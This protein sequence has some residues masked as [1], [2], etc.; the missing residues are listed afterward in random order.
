MTL[1]DIY[2]QKLSWNKREKKI[3]LV[4]KTDKKTF[5]DD[6]I[7]CRKK[8]SYYRCVIEDD[9]GYI[10]LDKKSNMK[11]SVEFAKYV[12]D[13]PL[14]ALGIAQKN[15][16]KWSKPFTQTSQG[17][18]SCAGK[19]AQYYLKIINH[20][21]KA[22]PEITMEKLEKLNP[23]LFYTK[24]LGLSFLAP[25]GWKRTNGNNVILYMTQGKSVE[26][27]I[28]TF[29]RLKK[30]WNKSDTKNPEELLKKATRLIT[31]TSYNDAKEHRDRLKIEIPA[32]MLKKGH[33]Q[34]DHIALKRT[35][36]L[37]R[38]ES[39]TLLWN[40]KHIYVFYITSDM[41]NLATGEFLSAIASMSFCSE[42]R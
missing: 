11:M 41:Q 12:Q 17:A 1:K 27:N 4:V 29:F 23:D 16:R 42:G 28:F 20:M 24:E 5:R 38:F 30:F 34:I 22:Y 3:A 31:N 19:D 14:V 10:L 32:K 2:I 6:Y 26:K 7:Y 18:T 40:G 9:G 36:K 13:E 15:K 33:Y 25:K 39:W 21:R 37:N 35:G 8:K